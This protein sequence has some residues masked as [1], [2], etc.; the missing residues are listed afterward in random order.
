MGNNLIS[1]SLDYF[2]S[3]RRT[4][5]NTWQRYFSKHEPASSRVTSSHESA[6]THTVRWGM[7]HGV[8]N[9]V[10]FFG[11]IPNTI[12]IS[13]LYSICCPQPAPPP[14]PHQLPRL[15]VP[16]ALQSVRE[17]NIV[18]VSEYHEIELTMMFFSSLSTA[19]FEANQEEGEK[20]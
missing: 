11:R 4:S 18:I 15:S 2:S 10:F 8:S 17:L 20:K 1:H 12:K 19:H 3:W 14:L 16:T 5:G 13:N 6:V 9:R 7:G